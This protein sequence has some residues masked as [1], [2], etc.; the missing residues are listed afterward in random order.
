MSVIVGIKNLLA[1]L[2]TN[3][4]CGTRVFCCCDYVPRQIDEGFESF[5]NEGIA[6]SD[7]RGQFSKK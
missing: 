6:S 2:V 1:L 3:F 7:S 4:F 5:T